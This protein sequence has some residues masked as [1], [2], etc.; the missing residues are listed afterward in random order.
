LNA[1]VSINGLTP[2]NWTGALVS[3]VNAIHGTAISLEAPVASPIVQDFGL[4]TFPPEGWYVNNANSSSTWIRTSLPG[5]IKSHRRFSKV[6][7]FSVATGDVDELYVQNFDFSDVNQQLA[8][9][10]V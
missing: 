6:S 1:A 7:F 5:H 9:L 4:I 8:Y 3:S 10:E 2:F